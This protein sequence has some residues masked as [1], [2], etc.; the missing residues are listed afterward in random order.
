MKTEFNKSALVL[1]IIFGILGVHRL[2]LRSWSGIAYIPAILAGITLTAS[3]FIVASYIGW[4]TIVL[5]SIFYVSDI[6]RI[7]VGKLND[8]TN[9]ARGRT[10][11]IILGL[12]Y[13][14]ALWFLVGILIIVTRVIQF[15][16]D[17]IKLK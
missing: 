14:L 9:E 16:V 3:P 1:A 8:S 4:C 5:V 17:P 6:Y 2:Y 13:A 10:K 15:P 11:F 7:C 12:F